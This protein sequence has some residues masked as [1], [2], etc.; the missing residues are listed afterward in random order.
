VTAFLQASDGDLDLTTGITPGRLTLIDGIEEKA[1]KIQNRL[2]IARGEWFLNVLV[3]T[4]YY[5]HILGMKAPD[6]EL[7]RRVF[8]KVIKSVEGIV[9]VP[10]LLVS[11]NENR[12]VEYSFRAIDDAGQ[13]ITG[14]TGVPCV[15]EDEEG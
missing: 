14:G 1:Q 12:E 15:I 7:I 5:E 9:D 4:P 11:L 8:L 10:E 6:L 13:V 2:G 3:G